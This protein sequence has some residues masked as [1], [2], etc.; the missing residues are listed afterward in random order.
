MEKRIIKVELIIKVI[1]LF[2]IFISGY[3]IWK[4]INAVLYKRFPFDIDNLD[5]FYKLIK[6]KVI[7][8]FESKLEME[9]ENLNVP[10]IIQADYTFSDEF[11]LRFTYLGKIL[12]VVKSTNEERYIG[13]LTKVRNFEVLMM[14][15][16]FQT[17]TPK[18]RCF[19]L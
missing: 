6:Q 11:I 9:L 17:A 3:F 16:E 12:L 5:K 1:A 15:L 4:K 19:V 7:P 14:G 10:E 8:R 18:I 2:A 13:D